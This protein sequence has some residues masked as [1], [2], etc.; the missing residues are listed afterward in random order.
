MTRE[1]QLTRLWSTTHAR[2]KRIAKR[3]DRTLTATIDLAV[4][5]YDRAA[6]RAIAA[7]R[8]GGAK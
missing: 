4:I 5:E 1:T 6:R 3:E 7:R 2:A 8:K